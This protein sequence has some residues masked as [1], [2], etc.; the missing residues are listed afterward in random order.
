[1]KAVPIFATPS[2]T[3]P[4]TVTLIPST[5]TRM[6]LVKVVSLSSSSMRFQS[7]SLSSSLCTVSVDHARPDWRRVARNL[8]LA[9]AARV[10]NPRCTP[11]EDLLPRARRPA[12]RRRNEAHRSHGTHL[13][14][15]IPGTRLSRGSSSRR[16]FAGN[17]RP[18]VARS[19][20][21]RKCSHRNRSTVR[22]PSARRAPVPAESPPRRDRCLG[23]ASRLSRG[24]RRP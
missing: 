16:R 23:N 14:S 17:A 1:M 7:A 15:G 9:R 19:S 13:R 5:L 11:P 21:A 2:T 6:P 10:R 8:D 4:R 20:D 22:A 12:C 18:N 3:V 24:R